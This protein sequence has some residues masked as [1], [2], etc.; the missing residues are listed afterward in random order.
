MPQFGIDHA[1]KRLG[2]WSP[3][4]N[5]ISISS[6]HLL[7]DIW[8]EVELTLKHEMAH[9][10]VSHA[11]KADGAK[12]HGALFKRAS[13]LLGL[14]SSP[15]GATA[16]PPD[17]Q[18]IY[19]RVQKL[20]E[21]SASSSQNEAQ[22][23]VTAAGRILLRHNLSLSGISKESDF[24]YRWVGKA[25]GKVSL[26]Q[27]I[28]SGILQDHFFVRSIW[29]QTLRAKAPKP[30]RVLEIMGRPENLELADYT[31]QFLSRTLDELW[32]SYRKT[33]SP[34][35]RGRAIRNAFR[36]GV[37]MGFREKLAAQENEH[38]EQG[39]IWLGDPAI[40][41][42]MARRYPRTQSMRAGRYRTGE[43]HHAG[44]RKGA[45]LRVRPGMKS[46]KAGEM[47]V[48]GSQK[49]LLPRR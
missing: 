10:Y 47:K 45:Q 4:T 12:P 28:L 29:V 18:R 21:L 2:Q 19:E 31:H 3:A 27:K 7:N 37:L 36:V 22:A 6:S 39:L 40:D 30:L 44:R 11:L 17:I 8:L 13:K 24:T 5:T 35:A 25:T 32:A 42:F 9:Q 16:T 41:E 20:M 34:E 49:R 1:Q 23:A 43:A 26:E 14:E 38:Q 46:E 15:R 33:L 48:K